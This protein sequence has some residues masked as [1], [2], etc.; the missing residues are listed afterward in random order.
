M[1][2]LRIRSY[3]AF[4]PAQ[5]LQAAWQGCTCAKPC[6]IN[7]DARCAGD[8]RKRAGLRSNTVV[9]GAGAP[10]YAESYNRQAQCSHPD[11]ARDG[12][13]TGNVIQI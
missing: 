4:Q 1:N 3:Q 9:R 2:A 5:P 6:Q 13:R 8:R 10:R 7:G 11:G 12:G